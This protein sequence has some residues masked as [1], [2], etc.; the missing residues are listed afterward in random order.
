MYIKAHIL[1]HG[2]LVGYMHEDSCAYHRYMAAF[3]CL[4]GP[5]VRE[6]AFALR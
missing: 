2:T 6:R 3:V 5:V 4:A 1:T